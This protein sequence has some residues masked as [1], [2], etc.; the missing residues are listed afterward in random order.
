MTSRARLLEKF[1]EAAASV[2][3]ITLIVAVMCLSFIPIT[4]DLML[5]FLIGAVLL[6][7]GMGLFTMGSDVSMTQIGTHMGAKLTRSKNLK[8]IL[9]VSLML[10]IAITVA[11]PD[12]QVA[13]V[14]LTDR[15]EQAELTVRLN[16]RGE[17]LSVTVGLT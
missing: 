4:T 8:L 17:A 3:P 6:I 10:G 13:G 15:G 1:K 5:S 2:L 7:V 14:E 16:W 11:E 9:T 12:L